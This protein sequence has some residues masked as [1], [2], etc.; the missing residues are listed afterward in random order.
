MEKFQVVIENFSGPLDKILELIESRKLDIS[1]VSLAK[2]TDDFLDYLTKFKSKFNGKNDEINEVIV[3]F[4]VVAT[5]L[6]LI[7]SMSLLPEDNL[8]E[9]EL[10]E[11]RESEVLESQL[12]IYRE[13]K[14]ISVELREMF[15][16]KRVMFKREVVADKNFVFFAPA[17]VKTFDLEKSIKRLIDLQ[18]NFEK[19]FKKIRLKEK[20]A[21]LNKVMNFAYK[22]I[23][24]VK[25]TSFVQLVQRKEKSEVISVF[26][27]LLHLANNGLVEIYQ[28]EPFS[29]IRI[30]LL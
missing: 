25:K 17:R 13:F 4:L 24:K 23:K 29:E 26:I 11:G 27:S 16:R 22:L 20:E 9:G 15:R 28:D 7:K 1:E 5:R 10:E 21:D 12:K 3:D 14:L 30:E 19:D 8:E 18:E 6:V 2:I